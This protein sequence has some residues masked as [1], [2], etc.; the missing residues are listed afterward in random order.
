VRHEKISLS[1]MQSF[2]QALYAG[3]RKRPTNR[4]ALRLVVDNDRD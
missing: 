1:P 3:E 4:P 2:D